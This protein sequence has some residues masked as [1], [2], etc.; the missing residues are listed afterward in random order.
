MLDGDKAHP[1]FGQHLAHHLPDPAVAGDDDVAVERTQR[2]ILRQPGW[3]HAAVDGVAQPLAQAGHKRCYQH[4][5]ADHDE[6]ELPDRAC[7]EIEAERKPDHDEGEFA[8]LAQQQA[9]FAC[10]PPGQAEHTQQH[11]DDQSL[12]R[13]QAH[14]RERNPHRLREQRA[15]IDA[16]AHR[17]EEQPHQQALEGLDGDLDFMTELGF[18]ND[19]A[20]QQRA[21]SH[22][23]AG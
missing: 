14:D 6:H 12:E 9:A 8:A 7:D 22:R 17:Q 19:E 10:P 18:R 3:R 23:Q 4:G 21:Q 11:G 5:H 2:Y 15:Q 16:H 13:K 1:L 20:G